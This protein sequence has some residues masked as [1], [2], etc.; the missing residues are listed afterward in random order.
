MLSSDNV[1]NAPGWIDLGSP[2]PRASAAFYATVFGWTVEPAGTEPA[3][4]ESSADSYLMLKKDGKYVGA[5]GG[6]GSPGDQSAWTVYVRVADAE[7]VTKAVELAGGSVR[8]APM[9]VGE[10]GRL[11]QLTDPHGANFALWQP[12]RTAGFG[13]VQQPGSLIWIELMTHH[14][15]DAK[16]FYDEV[17]GWKTAPYTDPGQQGSYD[18]V[19]LNPAE[20]MEAFGGIMAISE[21]FGIQDEAWTP[22]FHVEDVD[23]VVAETLRLGGSVVVPAADAP[24]GRLAALADPNGARFSLIKPAPMG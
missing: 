8:V 14:L 4:V 15:E 2:D 12:G 24:P 18:M 22:Y 3:D 11:A 1:S 17:F 21:G 19:T 23:A 7:A 13:L 10:E 20:P 9:D 6:L 5:V 16:R